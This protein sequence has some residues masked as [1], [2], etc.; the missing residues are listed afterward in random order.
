M[1]DPMLQAAAEALRDHPDHLRWMSYADDDLDRLRALLG[2]PRPS[3]Y[4]CGSPTYPSPASDQAK[5]MRAQIETRME[6]RFPP[7]DRVAVEAVLDEIIA[8][9]SDAPGAKDATA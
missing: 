4:N 2:L 7:S 5:Q 1:K 8:E 6:G 9:Q 3:G